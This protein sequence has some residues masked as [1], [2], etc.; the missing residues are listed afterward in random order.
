MKAEV[1]GSAPAQ[2][3]G[4][5]VRRKIGGSS[6][7]F[8]LPL[9]GADRPGPPPMPARFREATARILRRASQQRAVDVRLADKLSFVIGVF[10]CSLTQWVFSDVPERMWLLFSL[11][12]VPLLVIRLHMYMAVKLQLFLLDFCY[13]CLLLVLVH[14]HLLPC[15]RR[16]H[17]AL[18]SLTSGPLAI[19]TVAWRNS[20][21]F[22]SVDKVT[23]IFIHLLPVATLHTLHWTPASLCPSE[24]P[25]WGAESRLSLHEWLGFPLLIYAGWQLLYVLFVDVCLAGVVRLHSHAGALHPRRDAA[26]GAAGHVAGGALLAHPDAPGIFFQ[27]GFFQTPCVNI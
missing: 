24:P 11:A 4:G 22:H 2:M 5:V 20:L 9:L 25:G 13:L 21:V 17:F 19:A 3:E 15:N 16:L 18:F 27:T 26:G 12:I 8:T 6:S 7:M 23:S 10:G 14:I 1:A